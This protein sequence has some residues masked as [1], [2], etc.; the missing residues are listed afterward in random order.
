[1]IEQDAVLFMV[2]FVSAARRNEVFQINKHG[3]SEGNR[4]N[5][6]IGK[7]YRPV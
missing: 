3:L 2:M 1:M 5:E 6:V 4:A 7:R